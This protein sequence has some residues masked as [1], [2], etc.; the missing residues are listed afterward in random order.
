MGYEG[1]K[2]VV[3]KTVVVLGDDDN[4][5]L[6]T[7]DKDEATEAGREWLAE[8]CGGTEA[9]YEAVAKLSA[10]EICDKILDYDHV[11]FC[12]VATAVT[13]FGDDGFKPRSS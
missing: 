10:D 9:D 13:L 8:E 2:F 11:A 3:Y 1:A 6:M 5:Y 12:D 4:F 7:D